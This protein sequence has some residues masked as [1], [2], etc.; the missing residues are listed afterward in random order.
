VGGARE[1]EAG[2]RSADTARPPGGDQ[3]EKKT[4]VSEEQSSASATAY[5]SHGKSL[6][7]IGD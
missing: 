2:A 5:V 6:W 7:I 1:P 4:K 3:A